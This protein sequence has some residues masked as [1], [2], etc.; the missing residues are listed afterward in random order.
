M[1]ALTIARNREAKGYTKLRDYPVA[2]AAKI[3]KGAIVC[4]NTAGLA[5]NAADTASFVVAGIAQETVDNTSG[6]AGDKRVVCQYDREFLFT[7]AS[8]TQAMVGT[9]MFVVDNDTVDDAAGPTNDVPVGKLTEFISA[10][11]GWVYVPGL[12][13]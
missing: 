7:A 5:V 12:S 3:F 10:T 2:A 6:A 11:Q 13:I 1:A 8:I 4:L 9:Q